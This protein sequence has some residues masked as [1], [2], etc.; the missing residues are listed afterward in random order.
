MMN[1][2]YPLTVNGHERLKA[3]L[4]TLK[5]VDRPK[6]TQDIA[7]ARAHG[8]LKENAE[9]H[10][11]REQQG[12]VEARIKDL[13]AK[14]SNCD[15]ID[16]SKLENNGKVIF[17]AKVELLN[18]E[19]HTKVTYQIVGVDEADIKKGMI[20]YTSPIARGIMGKS[21]GDEVDIETPKSVYTYEIIDVVYG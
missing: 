15:V 19:D 7:D 4:E 18:V 3:E 10:A 21:S 17:G 12:L 8:D 11:A 5:R 20:S 1:T 9:Y 14:L 13:E 16:L 2:R 6:I